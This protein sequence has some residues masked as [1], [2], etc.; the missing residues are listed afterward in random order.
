[1]QAAIVPLQEKGFLVLEIGDAGARTPTI[2]QIRYFREGDKAVAESAARAL[3]E[4]A[5]L[6]AEV[7]KF[8]APH[9]SKVQHLEL[10]CSASW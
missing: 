8:P 5:K 10:W 9:N 6:T 1:M 7:V 3:E 4:T 2:S